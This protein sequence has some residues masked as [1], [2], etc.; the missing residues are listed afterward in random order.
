MLAAFKPILNF[1]CPAKAVVQRSANEGEKCNFV[2]GNIKV[3]P[4]I[5]SLESCQDLC[6]NDPSCVAGKWEDSGKPCTV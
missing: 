3:Y 5:S 2:G 1:R 4:R 6:Y